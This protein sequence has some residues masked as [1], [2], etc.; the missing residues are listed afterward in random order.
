VDVLRHE[1]VAKDK[2]LVPLAESFES[3]F[4]EDA[5]P[6]VVQV[7]ET[8]VTAEG[9]EVIVAFGLVSLQTARH[10][11]I[12]NSSILQ[13]HPCAMKLRMNGAPEMRWLVMGGPPAVWGWLR[14][15]VGHPPSLRLILKLPAL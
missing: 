2:E 13:P 6:V 4:K 5:G 1:D 15:R 14:R 7:R 9:D 11:V 3:L 8:P 12:V 10:G